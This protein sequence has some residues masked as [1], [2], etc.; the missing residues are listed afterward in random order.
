MLIPKMIDY[1]AL[2]EKYQ[3][4]GV[5]QKIPIERLPICDGYITLEC[6]TFSQSVIRLLKWL[7]IYFLR[8]IDW[9]ILCKTLHNIGE[10]LRKKL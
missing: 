2:W 9:P 7:F 1:V 10:S 3:R 6:A 8:H 4:E 5:P